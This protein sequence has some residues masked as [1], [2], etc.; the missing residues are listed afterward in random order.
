VKRAK[1]LARVTAAAV[2]GL[3][4]ATAV[5]ACADEPE[6]DLQEVELADVELNVLDE[7]DAANRTQLRYQLASED[8]DATDRK[9]P[10]Q[11]TTAVF[12]QGFTQRANAAGGN[13]T[14]P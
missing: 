11:E 13:Q 8:G 4:C 7:G 9:H 14:I 2:V 1:N 10:L 5:T 12:T 6:L 3:F